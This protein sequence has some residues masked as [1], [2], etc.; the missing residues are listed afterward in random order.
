MMSAEDVPANRRFTDETPPARILVVDD[1]RAI[2]T[3]L[4]RMLEAADYQVYEAADG[5][6]GLSA[7]RSEPPDL[8][9]L[10][11][12]MPVMDG[13][14]AMREMKADPE[15]E[16]VPVLFLTARTGGE[17][18]AAGL[19]LGAQDY[20]RKPCEA[21]EL[22][23]RVA[24]ALRLAAHEKALLERART[25]DSLSTTDALT[26]LGNRRYLE[27]RVE[28]LTAT[29][30]ADLIVGV[31]LADIDHFKRV[32]DTLGHATGDIVLRI[33]AARLRVATSPD[34]ILV[35]W[36]GE[37]FLAVV[38]DHDL[39]AAM[40]AGEAW[41]AALSAGPFAFGAEQSL[42]VTISVGVASGR[43]GDLEQLTVGADDGLYRAKEAGRNR[44]SH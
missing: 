41:R 10:D 35:R 34:T 4:R 42:D 1:S 39:S 5:R 43:L 12:D 32:N 29:F 18:V 21:A 33:A 7:M 17:D 38:P 11:I 13:L 19:G 25:L 22:T 6:D 16:S 20:L 2:R 24:S 40:A 30:G 15:L 44:V 8:V 31:L 9:L 26:G 28:E 27:N 3:I 36:G 14:S 37:E 23:A